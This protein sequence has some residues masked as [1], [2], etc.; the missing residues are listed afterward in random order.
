MENP[1]NPTQDL[2]V[3]LRERAKELSCLYRAD[4]ILS[5]GR[6]LEER[7]QK[8]VEVISDGWFMPEACEAWIDYLGSTFKSP[9]YRAGGAELS[10][11]LKVQGSTVGVLRVAY[12]VQ[13]PDLPDGAFLPEETRLISTL[14]QRVSQAILSE[15]LAHVFSASAD[16]DSDQRHAAKG[17]RSVLDMMSITDRR[18]Y[19]TLCR[20]MLNHLNYVGAEGAGELLERWVGKAALAQEEAE[21][22]GFNQPSSK[23][24][25]EISEEIAAGIIQVAASCMSDEQI[26]DLLQKW[27]GE[28]QID[29][30]IDILDD[31]SSSLSDI[32]QAIDHYRDTEITESS[33]SVATLNAVKV[34]LI[35]RFVSRRLEFISRAKDLVDVGDFREL[36]KF[37]VFPHASHG[38]LGGKGAGLFMARH[39]IRRAAEDDE[40]LRSVRFPRSWHI[41]SDGIVDFMHYNSLE[42]LLEHRYRDIDQIRMEYPN[43]LQLFKNSAFSPDMRRSIYSALDDLGESPIIVR[44]SSLLEDSEIAAFSGKHRSLFLANSGSRQERME[45]LLDAIAEVYASMFGPDPIE[46]RAERGLLDFQEE[47]GILIQEVV[48]TRVGPYFLPSFSGVAFSRNEFR[49]SAR[50]DTDDG[51]LRLVPGLGT[52][53]VDRLSDDYPVLVAPGKP[54]LRVN[55]SVEETIRHAPRFADVINLETRSLETVKL[56]D[57]L[58]DFG[59]EYPGMEQVFSVHRQGFLAQA[60]RFTDFGR[61]SVIPT[62]QGLIGRGSPFVSLMRTVMGTLEERCGYPVDVEFAH[63]SKNLYIL[64]CRAQSSWGSSEQVRIPEDVRSEDILFTAAKYVSDGHIPVLTHLVYVV[65]GEYDR[66][67]SVR[68]LKEVGRTVGR[69][70]SLLPKRRFALIGPGRW[71]SRGDIKLGVSV[72]YSEINNTALLVEAAFRKGN[73]LPDLSFGTHFFQ[74]LVESNIH[75]LPLYPDDEGIVFNRPFFEE[76]EN[77]LTSLLPDARE[78]EGVVR[79][80]DI[81]AA[82]NGRIARVSMNGDEGRAIAW[83]EEGAVQKPLPD[84]RVLPPRPGARQARDR[85]EHWLWRQQMAEKLAASMDQDQYGV[86]AIYLFG[87]TKHASAAPCSDIDLIVHFGGSPEDRKL[88]EAY[89]G[90]WSFSLGE[91]N[92][93]RTGHKCGPLLDV[94]IVT[95]EDIAAKTSFAAK[96]GA[97]SNPA[98]RLT[99][100]PSDDREDPDGATPR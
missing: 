13:Q 79:V 44:S 80:I 24:V 5:S 11:T 86:R 72:T 99:M 71:G 81:P 82:S 60:T 68:E 66:L 92:Y 3:S 49:W 96:I 70:N 61:E 90:G 7:L 94:H 41:A 69:L 77:L 1:E 35:R 85:E 22:S 4:E 84:K 78:L 15:S 63:D 16:Q 8:L 75:Y 36:S 51:L 65:P 67:E 28:N 34:S 58:R 54:E 64:E 25:M 30:L 89:L 27:I 23:H 18:L 56:E 97:R 45:A 50:I 19:A 52:R 21:G 43:L 14:A 47:M 17:W 40:T 76:S 37:L 6:P 10:E 9:G 12:P 46:Y 98:R 91:S 88:L 100:S 32:C 39:A 53:A 29:N 62:F 55:T 59:Q 31:H 42:E 83:L 74:D 38:Q 87:S 20:K 26:F 33:I 95:D 48:G 73:Y 57:L 93:V 2:L